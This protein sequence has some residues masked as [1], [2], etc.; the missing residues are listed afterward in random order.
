V[1]DDAL[2]QRVGLWLLGVLAAA[3]AG[4]LGLSGRPLTP[5]RSYG[6]EFARIGG[7]KVGAPV[8]LFGREVGRVDAIGFL[9]G[10][11]LRVDFWVRQRYREHVR[12]NSEVYIGMGGSIL[13]EPSLD[14]GPP[15]GTPGPELSPAALVRGVDPPRL[16]HV[17]QQFYDNLVALTD[18]LR[19]EK[20]EIDDFFHAADSLVGSLAGTGATEE[21]WVR[22]EHQ[23]AEGVVHALDLYAALRAGT[24]DGVRLRACMRE[25][26]RL[27]QRTARELAAV[28][29]RL[30][31]ALAGWERIQAVFS[32]VERARIADA[33]GKLRAA[34]DAGTAIAQ[35]LAELWRYVDSGRGTVGAILADHELIDDVKALNWLLQNRPWVGAGKPDHWKPE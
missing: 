27:W 18:A 29:P 34:A 7:L 13:G 12:Q 35:S 17:L 23:A 25:L 15:R 6:A 9:R 10:G 28:R 21:Q 4:V 8:K 3:A 22:I 16:D 30:A 11:N 1:N 2:N 20:T 24:M 14:I 26:E 31:R 19:D 5:V 32:P 33:L